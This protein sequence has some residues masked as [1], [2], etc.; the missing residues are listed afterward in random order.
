MM[1]YAVIDMDE[2]RDGIAEALAGLVP[3]ADRYVRD[4]VGR[5]FDGNQGM[6]AL[7]LGLV[8]VEDHVFPVLRGFSAE[9]LLVHVDARNYVVVIHRN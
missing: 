2:G 1:R 6:D 7:T 5:A 4:A 8:A 3:E 9:T